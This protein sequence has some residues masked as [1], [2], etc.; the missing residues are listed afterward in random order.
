MGLKKID[1][2]WRIMHE[3]HSIPAAGNGLDVKSVAPA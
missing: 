1:W 2:K 3:H